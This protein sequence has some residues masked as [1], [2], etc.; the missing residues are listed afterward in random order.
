MRSPVVSLLLSALA[1]GCGCPSGNVVVASR[2]VTFD[3]QMLEGDARLT[4]QG[5]SPPSGEGIS[6]DRATIAGG[7]VAGPRAP[8]DLLL[9][10]MSPGC[11]SDATGSA[12]CDRTIQVR[13]T[14]HRVAMGAASYVLDDQRAEMEIAVEVPPGTGPC[15]GKPGLAGCAAADASASAPYVAQHDIK[16]LLTMARLAEDCTDAIAGCALDARGT[17]DVS[18]QSAGGD[19]IALASGAVIAAD[20]LSYQDGKTCNQ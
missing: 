2:D 7:A 15:P 10:A 8:G 18:A 9:F 16:G 3:L 14:I 20:T 6:F 11:H 1:F 5:S 12:V 19:T 13:L 4:G 17:F